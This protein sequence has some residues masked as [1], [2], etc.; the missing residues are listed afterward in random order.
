VRIVLF[1]A[2]LGNSLDLIATA[3]GIHWLG[4]REGNPLLANLAHEHWI[5]FVA[6]KGVLIPLLIVQLYRYRR[7]TPRLATFGMA[8]VT[9]ALTIAVGQWLGWIAGVIHVASVMRF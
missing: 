5:A 8:L 4:N 9:V 3:L 1:I 6:L 2:L 7:R